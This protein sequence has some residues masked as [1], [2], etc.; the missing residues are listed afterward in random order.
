VADVTVEKRYSFL[1]L[2]QLAL[3]LM[4]AAPVFWL[5]TE[6]APDRDRHTLSNAD[7]FAITYPRLSHGFGRIA[8]GE[9]PLWDPTQLCGTPYWAD[10]RNAV[11]QPLNIVFR[12]IPIARAMAVHGFICLFLMGIG[13]VLWMR[14]LELRY[15]PA[16]FAAIV[17]AF[18]GVSSAAVARPELANALAWTPFVLWTL[19]EFLERF[20][21]SAAIFCGLTSAL[22]A[23]SGS[24]ALILSVMLFAAPYAVLGTVWPRRTCELRAAKRW[25]VLA[26]VPAIALCVS[27]VQWLPAFE[28]LLS[29]ESPMTVLMDVST[30]ALFPA[31][32]WEAYVHAVSTRGTLSPRAFYFGIVT[33]IVLPAAV[34]HERRRREMLIALGVLVVLGGAIFSPLGTLLPEQTFALATYPMTICIAFLAGLGADRLLAPRQRHKV[35]LVI[36]PGL[37]ALA[38]AAG[39]VY[40]ST[41]QGR[42]EAIVVAVLLIPWLV[43]RARWIGAVVCAVLCALLYV[44]LVIAGAIHS[45]HP[46]TEAPACYTKYDQVLSGAI[47]Y[48]ENARVFALTAP[49]DYALPANVG[50]LRNIHAAGGQRIAMTTDQAAWWRRLAENSDP[51]AAAAGE[52]LIDDPGALRLLNYMAVATAVAAPKNNHTNRLLAHPGLGWRL[53]ET[54]S[55]ARALGNDAA[56]PRAYWM[57]HARLVDGIGEAAALL[58]DPA[59]DPNRQCVIE[60]DGRIDAGLP[61]P[62]ASTQGLS[63]TD[64]TCIVEVD[65]PEEVVV[66]LK[67]PATGYLVLC[68]SYAPGWRAEL[69]GITCP[70]LKANGLFRAIAVSEGE[71]RVVFTYKPLSYWLGLGISVVTLGIL[72][73]TGLV[74]IVRRV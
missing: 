58:A 63:R 48:R 70:I 73:L 14:S 50:S 16:L 8:N 40:V 69:N 13:F 28:W 65:K 31:S 68:D 5:R 59:F 34:L 11:M 72:S 9:S 23:L 29:L 19:H 43:F 22:L 4:I 6:I 33:L 1:V 56:L 53:L 21:R 49:E 20:T 17:F 36:A 46:Y 47:R 15:M 42:G 24:P 66:R 37:L 54:V 61:L 57:P 27:A 74:L 41:S 25:A 10:P 44:D 12:L 62:A 71:H 18:S 39:A 30:P 64:A 35:V 45:P 26:I 60:R 52:R 32:L 38:A 3:V 51:V 67:A 7:L 55:G 2:F